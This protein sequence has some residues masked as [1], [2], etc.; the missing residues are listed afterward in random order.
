VRRPQRRSFLRLGAAG[1]AGWLL[2]GAAGRPVLAADTLVIEHARVHTGEGRR[3]DDGAVVLRGSTILALGA[4]A[5]VR[6]P[7]GARRLDGRGL[8]VT[9]GLFDAESST[10]LV[11][12]VMEKSSVET[13]LDD[14]YD[15]I[16]AAFLVVDG[17][18]P[19]AVAIP[20]T[21]LEGVTA[22]LAA[23]S[24][25]LV[26]GRGAVLRL[27]GDRVDQ[28]LVRSPVAAFASMAS[29]GRSAAYGARG[30]LLLRLRELF[31]D[32]RQYARRRGDFERN[33]MRRV[34][35]SRLDLEALIPVV[36]GRLPLVIEVHRAADIQA[37]LRLGR[38]EKLSLILT[39]CEEGWLVAADI[40]AAKVPVV[41][42]ALP[43]LPRSFEALS[44][45][46]DNA[47]L[48]A[49]AGVKI[50][51]SP[52]ARSEHISRTL[53]L[54]AGNAVANGLPWEVALAAITRHPAEIYGVGKEVGTLAPGSSADLVVWSGDP[55]EPLTRPRH[56]LIAGQEIPLVSRQ[57][58]LRDRYRKLDN[59][60]P[61]P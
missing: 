33:Q 2:A 42:S 46:L 36:E 12:V 39:G 19:R 32:V 60:R 55:F 35:A 54:E 49:S 21:R 57:T 4:A 47:A 37:A 16:R 51:L 5:D 15:A 27:N 59:A 17:F 24:G 52:R 14:K 41:V 23:P 45:R 9:P 43:N 38:E 26:A 50:A 53:R 58:L 7:E 3:F 34:A 6:V 25:G 11:D 44:A 18:N 1:G 22:V 31:D 40:A 28:M 8:V 56:V 13:G 48:L 29:D 20:V 10:G 30:G 61:R